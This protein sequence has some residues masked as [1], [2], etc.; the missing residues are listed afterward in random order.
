M[1]WR[2]ESLFN[3][4]CCENRTAMC[5]RMKVDHYLSPYTKIDS[6]CIKDLNVRPEII[7]FVEENIGSTLFDISLSGIFLNTMSTQARKTKEKINKWDYIRL[8]SFYKAKET[9]NKTKIQ[10]S[11]WKKIFANHTSDKGLI[12]K[13]Y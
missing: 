7:K 2:K 10:P 13:I 5:K 4:W 3:K 11:N 8:K 6:K 1:Q 12:S 9:R